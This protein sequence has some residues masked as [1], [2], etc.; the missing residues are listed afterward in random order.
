MTASQG[1]FPPLRP[2]GG[3]HLGLSGKIPEP[4]ERTTDRRTALD[5]RRL[6]ADAH[7]AVTP[8]RSLGLSGA[9]L[10]V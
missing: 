4:E 10:F 8:D 6:P 2:I 9:G 5:F 7:Q 3:F 1:S